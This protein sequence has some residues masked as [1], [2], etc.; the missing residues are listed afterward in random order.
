[1]NKASEIICKALGI[2]SNAFFIRYSLDWWIKPDIFCKK[3]THDDWITKLH[4]TNYFWIHVFWEGLRKVQNPYKHYEINKTLITKQVP[5]I[6]ANMYCEPGAPQKSIFFRTA[7]SQSAK[8]RTQC[9][10]DVWDQA[11]L[12]LSQLMVC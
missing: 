4:I 5:S 3:N 2:L 10:N 7:E 1:M 11:H 8:C 12:S 6:V 9:I